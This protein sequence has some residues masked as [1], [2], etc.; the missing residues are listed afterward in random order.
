MKSFKTLFP[1]YALFFLIPLL[2]PADILAQDEEEPAEEKMIQPRRL[3]DA[4]TAGILP[5]AY[6][7]FE[8][9]IYPSGSVSIRGCGLSLGISV[10]ITNRLN[11][12][13]SYGGDGLIGRSKAKGN[14]YPGAFIKYRI[15]EESFVLP[16]IAIGYDHQGFGGIEDSSYL[17]F[18]YKSQGFFIALSKNFLFFKKIQFGLHG[19]VN[20]SIE[21][22][23]NVKWPNCYIGMDLGI[24]EELAFSIEY[25]CAL[26][27]KDPSSEKYANILKGFFNMGIRYAFTPAFYLEFDAKDIFQQKRVSNNSDKRMG[28]SRELK[29]VY[30]ASFL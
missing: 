20:F 22:V 25:D 26:N 7:D 23:R 4:H 3:I 16:G 19:A 5:R 18:V 12:G 8:T 11:F 30:L 29:I 27:Q 15:I 17:G 10:G 1:F 21:D 13:I 14:P 2:F 28:W 6:F 9:R 24:N